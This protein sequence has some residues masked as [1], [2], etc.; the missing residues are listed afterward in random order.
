MPLAC[1]IYITGLVLWLTC[2]KILTDKSSV[3]DKWITY[4]FPVPVKDK[5]IPS[6]SSNVIIALALVTLAAV[7]AGVGVLVIMKYGTL[8]SII[9]EHKMKCDEII[10]LIYT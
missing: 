6:S 3:V 4:L 10:V 2:F 1:Y 5:I 7:V 9:P 8:S